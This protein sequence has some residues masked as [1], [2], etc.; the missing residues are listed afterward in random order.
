MLELYTHPMSPCA[1]KVRIVLAEKGLDW[2]KHTVELSQKENL[3]PVY[4]ALNPLGVVPTLV[5]KGRPIIESS[6]ICEYLDDTFSAH[7]LKPS[8]SYQVAQMRLWMKH[9]D[10]KLHPSCGALQ[11]P[12]VMRPALMEKSQSERDELLEKIPEKPRRERQK[13]LVQYGLDAP[14][15]IDG[16]NL[17]RKTI[18]DMEAALSE[19]QWIVSDNFSLADVCLAPY[20]QTIYQFGWSDMYKDCPR[21]AAW[22]ER[23]RGRDSYLTSVIAD[24]SP[25][26]EADLL[27]KGQPAW[28]I[29]S[30]H[31]A[32][33][34]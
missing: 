16:I 4:L 15:V 7:S 24:F 13:R 26:I 23:C 18:L 2:T 17:Y 31:L 32:A 19:H 9:V 20:F 28:K 34:R 33:H 25:E 14:D 8:S 10:T 5:D 27:A 12:I 11:W 22:F 1:Q 6:I 21:V 3:R 29:I 30:A